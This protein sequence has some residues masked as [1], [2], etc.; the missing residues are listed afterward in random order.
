[1]TSSSL[2]PTLGNSQPVV[3]GVEVEKLLAVNQDGES[4]MEEYVPEVDEGFFVGGE[5]DDEGKDAKVDA[6][7]V[8]EENQK[9]PMK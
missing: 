7:A 1:M 4:E 9:K 8:S 6:P 2:S 5:L 3:V